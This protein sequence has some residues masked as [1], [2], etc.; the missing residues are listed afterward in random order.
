[1]VSKFILTAFTL[2]MLVSCTNS[3]EPKMETATKEIK[4][5]SVSGFAPVN[6]IQFYYE[7]H[8]EGK[9]L[10][11]IHGGGS[12]IQTS[13]SVLLPLFAQHHKVIAV[14][15]QA[16]GHTKDRDT[17][18]SFVQDADD[19]AAL[20][21]YLK[22]DKADFLGFSNGGHTLIEMGIRHP[23]IINKL[24]IISS[25]YKR[26]GAFTGFFDNMDHANL[27]NMP[28]P[29][30]EAYLKIPGNDS[31]GLIKMF[32]QDKNRMIHF[33]DWDD[34]QL[35]SIKAPCFI[36]NGTQDVGT[37]EHSVKMAHIIPGAEL[38]ILP[39]A[40]GSFIGE[41]CTAIPGSKMPEMT[42]I[43]IEE[44]LNKK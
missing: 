31:A 8:G 3:N 20:L 1:M 4:K 27:D 18:S 23:A 6:G 38:M 42:A 9:P 11:L 25:F 39:G 34:Q 41:I 10:V 12:T 30:K 36:I 15:L 44:F 28:A 22:I 32:N 17:A 19:V 5:D 13:F 26:E 21:A 24:I 35:A 16:H 14:E 43:A 29:L 33:K 40:H 37:V 7:I 2:F